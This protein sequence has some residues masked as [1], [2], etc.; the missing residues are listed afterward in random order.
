VRKGALYTRA[1]PPPLVFGI[2]ALGDGSLLAAC[3]GD[4]RQIDTKGQVV[5]HYVMPEGRG[6]AVV[7]LRAGGESFW[8]LDFFGGKVACVEIASGAILQTKELG[9]AKC[10]AGIAEFPRL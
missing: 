7:V 10:L 3:G 6:W 9:L 8:A 2:A 4:V 1:D 5:R